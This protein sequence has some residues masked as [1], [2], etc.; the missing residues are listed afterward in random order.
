M[1]FRV[2]TDEKKLSFS[3]ETI[4]D[5]PQFIVTDI[6]KLRQVFINVIGN[7]VKFTAEGGVGLR[8]WADRGG[9]AGP[10]LQVE[11]EDTG[12]GIS[13]DELGRLFRHFE[14]TKTGQQTGTGTGLG[15]AISREFVRL[16]GG[17]ITVSSWVGKG[18]VF[19]IRLPMLEG[20]ARA[21]PAKENP[22]HVLSLQ[23][24]QAAC[25][26]LIADDIEDNRQL[27]A[28]LLAPVGFEIRLATN[29]AEAV[30]EFEHWRPHLVLMDF[31]MPVMDGHEAI[32]RIRALPGGGEVKIIAVTASAMDDNRQE[33]M[34]VGS[35]DFIGKPFREAELFQ[36]IHAHVGVEY[37]YAEHPT[38]AA[39][40]GPADLTPASLVGWPPD[41]I[42]PMREAVVTAD[43]DQLLARIQ[44]VEAR[45][46]RVARGLRRLAEGFQYQKLLDLFSPG[47]DP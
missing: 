42:D 44:E 14:Q 35:D 22:R 8:I 46:P 23:P 31:R 1:M 7:A 37:V 15:L 26:V 4:G 36:K 9:A 34:A 30:R 19:V 5:V 24:G 13:A 38:A 32:R 21:V 18:S 12:P 3:M 6:N 17:D 28:Q 10:C 25:R 27:L 33:L 29:G 11:V 40:E 2:R 43:L 47:V 16:M 39:P 45:D 20:E 41:L